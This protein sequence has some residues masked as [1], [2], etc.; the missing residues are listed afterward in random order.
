M[1]DQRK[2]TICISANTSWNL[3]NFRTKL[4][5]DLISKGYSVAAISPEDKYTDKLVELGV[6]HFQI[7]MDNK[8]LNV[9]EDIKVLRQYIRLYRRIKPDAVLHFTIKPVIYGSLAA[10]LVGVNAINTMTG[11]GTAFISL[12]YIKYLI[13]IVL[14]LALQSSRIV[15]F[16]NHEDLQFFDTHHLVKKA[17]SK[18][19]GGSGV[20]TE[21]FS[22]QPILKTNNTKFLFVGRLLRDKGIIEFIEAA[23]IVIAER[24]NI[25][26]Q[27]LGPADVKNRSAL[28]SIELDELLSQSSII[29]LGSKLDVRQYIKDA[30]CVVLPSY[31]EGL[32]RVLLEA[33]S[34]GRP[35]IASNVPGCRDVVINGHNGFICEEKNSKDLAE[36]I[37]LLESLGHRKISDLGLNGRA[38]VK[39]LF[40]EKII[41]SEYI[42]AIER[43]I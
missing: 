14:R 9:W 10:K 8:G 5:R 7:N 19:I 26:F 39:E 22:F 12:G 23:K 34:M 35:V 20:D 41:V 17:R 25:E 32:S 6:K 42:D 16:H 43:A 2:T 27:I 40:S 24:D 28:S 30:H 4:I 18:V 29:Y 13:M 21:H 11:L 3:S 15:Y 1:E 37:L 31:R 38:R 33:G 36:K